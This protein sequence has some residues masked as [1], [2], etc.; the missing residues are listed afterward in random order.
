MSLGL[1]RLVLADLWSRLW[2]FAD[3]LS[4]GKFW[5]TINLI[6]IVS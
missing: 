5:L 1:L 2:V 4:R 6:Q 3:R